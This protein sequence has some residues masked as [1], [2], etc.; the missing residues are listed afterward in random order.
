MAITSTVRRRGVSE[1]TGIVPLCLLGLFVAGLLLAPLLP[2]T[3][4]VVTVLCLGFLTIVVPLA[5]HLQRQRDIAFF[6]LIPTIIS[7]TQNVYLLMAV[8]T[9]DK[10]ELQF[11][12]VINFVVAGVV[13]AML[14]GARSRITIART[15]EWRALHRVAAATVIVITVYGAASA[16]LFQASII[17]AL[18]SY[19]NLITPML[20]FSIGLLASRFASPRRYMSALVALCLLAVVFGLVEV[21]TPRFWQELGIARLWEGKDIGV[22][23]TTGIPNNFYSSEL[24]GGRQTRRMVGPFA[25]PVNFGTFLFAAFMAA[26]ALRARFAAIV[27]VFASVLAVSKGALVSF[28]AFSAFWT[29]YFSSRTNHFLAVIAAGGAGLY[30]YGFATG[31]STGSVDAHV[32]GLLAAFVE[33]PQHPLGRGMGNIGVLSTLFTEGAETQVSESGFGMVLGQLGLVGGIAYAVFFVAL[34]RAALRVRSRRARLLTVGLLI[35]ITINAAFN[36]VALSP[37][38]SAPYFI[39]IGLVIGRDVMLNQARED[40]GVVSERDLAIEWGPAGGIPAETRHAQ[41]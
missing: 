12:V 37:N 20:F 27:A 1:S 7:A 23:G 29:R 19:R 24:I 9:F 21:T 40:Y 18:A 26:W 35:G 32:G 41:N 38:S 5:L 14:L 31:N 11:A 16:L 25:D 39:I 13:W 30:F 6:L 2:T 34:V 22:N 15:G 10:A 8:D 3:A 36:E 33:L 17:P 4:Y 28:L